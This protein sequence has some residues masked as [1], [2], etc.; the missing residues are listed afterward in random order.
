MYIIYIY[1]IALAVASILNNLSPSEISSFIYYFF[2][3]DE[4]LSLNNFIRYR[5]FLWLTATVVFLLLTPI[6]F[7]L[8]IEKIFYINK[9]KLIPSWKWVFLIIVMPISWIFY[10]IVFLCSDCVTSNDVTY[11][12]L[13]I[14]FFCALQFVALGLI[15]KTQ[16]LLGLK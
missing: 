16:T 10:P 11:F 3:L 4:D 6:G 15:L 12:F 7:Y 1:F 9:I 13:T 5:M 14:L 2:P 8:W